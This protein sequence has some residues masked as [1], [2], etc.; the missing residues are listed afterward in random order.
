MHIGASRRS[1]PFS[2]V[3][4]NAKATVTSRNQGMTTASVEDT[5]PQQFD[6]EVTS[7]VE[8]TLNRVLELQRLSMD[9]PDPLYERAVRS[10]VKFDDKE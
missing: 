7:S 6:Y 4:S 9:E 10:M 5:K 3:K 1:L 2:Q 8:A